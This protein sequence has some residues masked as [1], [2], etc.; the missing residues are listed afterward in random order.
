MLSLTL[1]ARAWV[2]PGLSLLLGACSVSPPPPPAMSVAPDRWSDRASADAA[3]ASVP[4]TSAAWWTGLGDP[5]IDALI[6]ASLAGNP[7]LE[8]A[9]ARVDQARAAAGIA[10]SQRLPTLTANGSA[11]RAQTAYVN[12]AG[13]SVGVGGNANQIGQNLDLLYS[14]AQ[15]GP[16]LS[17]ELDLWGRVRQSRIAANERLAAR[18]AD[19]R[20]ARL[21]IEAEVARNVAELRACRYS[22]EI[23]DGDI[24][25]RDLELGLI[26][27]RLSAGNVARIDEASAIGNL[28]A[29]RTNRLAQAERCDQFDNALVALSGL[30]L[31]TV[32]SLMRQPLANH[33]RIPEP[34]PTRPALPATV[35]AMHPDIVS[36]RREVDAAWADIGV[37]RAERLPRLELDAMLAGQWLTALGKTFSILAWSVGPTLSGTLFD[38]GAGSSKVAAARGRYREAVANLDAQLREAVQN[39]ENALARQASADAR[40]ASSREARQ[41]ADDALRANEARWRAGAINRFELETSRRQF[42]TAE[43]SVIDAAR[44]RCTAWIALVKATGYGPSLAPPLPSSSGESSP[45]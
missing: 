35:L 29:S 3:V 37:A 34:P 4:A 22:L 40:L 10:A 36:A 24:A 43:E 33:A 20:S 9:A 18:N 2:I 14:T 21:A 31:G 12:G 25:S 1:S 44:D 42:E 38:G 26:R 5:A 32:K 27:Q 30:D 8:Q 11:S 6:Q 28:A 7:T 17:W 16:A 39:V 13:N 41:A 19:A 45:S 15:I 23:R